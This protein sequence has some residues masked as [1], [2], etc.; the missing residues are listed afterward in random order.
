ML[1]GKYKNDFQDGYNQKIK[2]EHGRDV[3]DTI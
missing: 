1:K 3:V 2:R